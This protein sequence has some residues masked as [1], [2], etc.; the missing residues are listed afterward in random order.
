MPVLPRHAQ[1]A[2]S[3]RSVALVRGH[4]IQSVCQAG[5]APVQSKLQQADMSRRKFL[6]VVSS[7]VEPVEKLLNPSWPSCHLTESCACASSSS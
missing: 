7:L 3:D 1:I 5:Y 4:N 2:L 6:A